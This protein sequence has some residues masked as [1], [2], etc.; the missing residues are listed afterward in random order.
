[1]FLF[2]LCWAPLAAAETTYFY[3]EAQ[4][5][6]W[7]MGSQ[8]VLFPKTFSGPDDMTASARVSEAFHRL[9]T[10]RG[11]MYAG[12]EI[13]LGN[14]F[15]S[16]GDVEVTLGEAAKSNVRVVVSEV[17]WT[18]TV[19]GAREIRIPQLKKDALSVT[20]IPLGAAQVILQLWQILP[21]RTPGPG[22]VNYNGKL[23]KASEIRRRLK[24]G[25]R[26]V[27]NQVI[28]LLRNP[29]A[30]VRI[31]AV[32]ALTGL[33]L[34]K[35]EANRR[36]AGL[37]V[38]LQDPDPNVRRVVIKSFVGTRSKRTLSA[39]EKVVKTDPVA[40]L[41]TA[42]VRILTA[43]GNK[44]YAVFILFDKLKDRD[45]SV[46]M[47]AIEKLS[48]ETSKP[49]V[50]LALVDVLTHRSS[51]V[52]DLAMAGIVG[53]N[54]SE[55]LRKIVGSEFAARYRQRAAKVLSAGEGEDADLALR[56]LIVH[57]TEEQQISGIGQVAQRRRYKLVSVVIGMLDASSTPAVRKSAAEALGKIK[58]SK[59]L[60]PLA[61]ALAKFADE[62]SVLEKAI[63]SIFGGLGVDEVIRFSSSENASLRQLSIKSL[64]NI[65]DAPARVVSVL[66]KRLDDTEPEI[67]RSAAYSLAR[68]PQARVVAR[69]I[70][71]KADRDA[72][73]RQ[74]VAFALVRSKRPDANELLIGLL[75]DSDAETKRIAIDGLRTRG[76][77]EA[78]KKLRTVAR[79]FNRQK[80]PVRQVLV[81]AI[82]TLSGPQGWDTYKDFYT[83]WLF[84]TDPQVKVWSIR[85]IVGRANDPSVPSLLAPLVKD[86]NT[87]VQVEAIKALGK[88]NNVDAVDYIAGSLFDSPAK[89]KLVALAALAELN[90][91][92]AKQPIRDLIT[93]ETDKAVLAKANEVYDALP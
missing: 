11:P 90:L 77:T 48:K 61:D 29:V 50:A 64:G 22:L 60:Q 27:V 46:V 39:L 12:T 63:I 36:E 55:A 59:A 28:A 62:R 25:E 52:A 89:V 6:Q 66:M 16:S 82:V 76:V 10:K 7:G 1:M 83:A 47:E 70:K 85:G 79:A 84:D 71:L 80:T 69:L 92:R 86:S 18:L 68:I 33:R 73:I 41:K 51:Q 65:Q 15:A 23:E 78:L 34:A 87:D 32:N 75:S 38:A 31:Q 17:Y 88:T 26:S 8:Q 5:V 58:D 4:T 43:A 40:D 13:R 9:R 37:I 67:R 44:E 72:K 49:G 2:I 21:P 35:P 57:G 45:D 91:E 53:F 14:M 93:N 30:F 42:A 56:Y 24:D 19:A 3:Y 81:Q 20:D 54:N 74:Q